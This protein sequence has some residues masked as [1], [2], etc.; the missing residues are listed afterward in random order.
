MTTNTQE[1]PGASIL[2]QPRGKLN[3]DGMITAG[4]VVIVGLEKSGKSSLL[5]SSGAY[6]INLDAGDSDHI[7]GR[8]HDIVAVTEEVDGEVKIVKSR[9]A[10]FREVITAVLADDSIKVV[11]L[12]TFGTFVKL[13]AQEI[14]EAAGLNSITDRKEGV[15]GYAL[16]DELTA[17]TERFINMMRASG[18][19]F[20][21]NA[22]CK[23]PELNDEK[24]VVIPSG[25][26]TYNK[27]GTM[28]ARRADLIGYAYKKEVGGKNEY[29]LSFQGGPLGAW[30][31]RV[32]ALN[33]KTVK[34]DK[35]NPWASLLAAAQG[36]QEAAA[37]S[38]E[39][40][41][42]KAEKSRGSK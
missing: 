9:L 14:A 38:V 27:P 5:A 36:T 15:N 10:I 19:L 4:I 16:W 29:R 22:H 2:V 31:S 32:D 42:K 34:L 1:K 37:E 20:I 13:Q 7:D 18:K 8:I 6:V 21:I 41:T 23:A 12:D 25:I 24:Q 40:K 28:L 39:T 35:K 11:G 33:D 3:K 17:R 30:G 26:D